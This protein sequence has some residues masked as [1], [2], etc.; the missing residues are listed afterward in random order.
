MRLFIFII[1]ILW[2]VA[3]SRPAYALQF[4]WEFPTGDPSQLLVGD[5][6][7]EM[8]NT[9]VSGLNEAPCR[10]EL[11]AAPRLLEGS[12]VN[13][14]GVCPA[15]F[16]EARGWT[17]DGGQKR[18]DIFNRWDQGVWSGNLDENDGSFSGGAKNGE[19]FRLVPQFDSQLKLPPSMVAALDAHVGQW[20]VVFAPD[21]YVC[22]AVLMGLTGNDGRLAEFN[23]DCVREHRRLRRFVRAGGW[24][25][26]RDGRLAIFEYDVDDLWKGV[27]LEGAEPAYG[28]R[29]RRDPPGPA[30][31]LQRIGD[32]PPPPPEEAIGGRYRME[33]IIGAYNCEVSLA[34]EKFEGLGKFKP[35]N[36][37]QRGARISGRGCD[38][39]WEA[40]AWELIGDELVLTD[41]E[42]RT[43]WR[44]NL[45][46]KGVW[47]GV[48]RFGFPRRLV[49][50]D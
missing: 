20:R 22:G 13:I 50:A 27:R 29:Q 3:V 7:L 25:L 17:Y 43:V 10:I 30:V 23:R 9:T 41:I 15:P 4:E 33:N 40:A 11:S 6:S 48:D 45:A 19:H 2:I 16:D 24:R 18:L 21:N 34:A 35:T 31:I 39:D 47:L 14:G 44:G 26:M 38:L 28:G 36:P 12:K 32:L 49:L 46:F 8:A 42:N 1:F 37:N 5:Y